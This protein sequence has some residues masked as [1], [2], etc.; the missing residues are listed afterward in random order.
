MT[1]INDYEVILKNG[2]T[3][4]FA[5]DYLF[6]NTFSAIVVNNRT[7]IIEKI[8]DKWNDFKNSIGEL[9]GEITNKNNNS[10]KNED[11]KNDQSELDLNIDIESYRKIKNIVENYKIGESC[12]NDLTFPGSV[13]CVRFRKTV[14][15]SLNK[16]DISISK[17]EIVATINIKK[18]FIYQLNNK[19]TNQNLEN[20]LEIKECK[21][22]YS[23]LQYISSK[24]SELFKELDL[25]DVRI[26]NTL[27]YDAF[28]IF[29]C[30]TYNLS[31]TS[32]FLNCNKSNNNSFKQDKDIILKLKSKKDLLL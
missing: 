15:V 5:D 20:L 8:F 19:F 10:S 18:E 25:S 29:S 6:K 28:S 4:S 1:Y 3:F 17:I 21:N 24:I 23:N 14:Q 31:S 30:D 7:G 27:K 9:L 11:L 26:L 13:L 16:V 2:I 22:N 32:I 12:E